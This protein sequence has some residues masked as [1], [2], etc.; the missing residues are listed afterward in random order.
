[1]LRPCTLY[2]QHSLLTQLALSYAHAARLWIVSRTNA[3]FLPLSAPLPNS[4]GYELLCCWGFG[5]GFQAVRFALPFR[6]T[7]PFQ[8]LKNKPPK[9]AQVPLKM[10]KS[11]EPLVQSWVIMAF[12]SCQDREGTEVARSTTPWNQPDQAAIGK[13]CMRRRRVLCVCTRM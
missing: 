6:G 3:R 5:V 4:P 7:I 12:S 13:A 2:L 1:M 8:L 9:A 10:F 11:A